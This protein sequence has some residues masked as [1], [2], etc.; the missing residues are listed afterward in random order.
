M[1]EG[2]AAAA[3][4]GACPADMVLV[5]GDYCPALVHTCLEHH[6]EYVRE[7][8]RLEQL[9]EQG[10]AVG[11][12]NVAERCLR[13]EQPSR[14]VSRRRRP[15]RFCMD[16]YE[17]PNQKGAI[18]RVLTSWT[19]ARQLCRDVGKRLCTEHEFN[20]ACE[21]EQLLPYAYGYVRD[22][23]KCSI[24]RP[25]VRASTRLMHYEACQ[26]DPTC[27]QELAAVDQRVPAGAM[28]GCVSPFGVYDLNGNVDE[29][30]MRV[31]QEA[32]SRSGLKGGWWG[33]LRNRCR[34]MT[35]FHKESDYGYGIGLRCCKNAAPPS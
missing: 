23:S 34:P 26:Q 22:A 27:R 12:S 11:R 33:P 17:W 7:Q 32:P 6:A 1:D 19:Q 30:V 24:D 20:F 3:S 35:K 31:G 9:R 2:G 21:G 8:Q 14:C 29:W 4:G 18:P 15:M 28:P 25:Y 16:R 10:K 5:A 13:F